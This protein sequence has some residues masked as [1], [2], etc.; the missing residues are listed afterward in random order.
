MSRT[1][2]I[3]LIFLILLIPLA[4]GCPKP[5]RCTLS[6][7][8]SRVSSVDCRG[9]GFTY[10]PYTLD[11]RITSLDMSGN[12]LRDISRDQLSSYPELTYLDLSDNEIQSVPAKAFERL[13]DLEVL[14]LDRNGIEMIKQDQFVG[15]RTLKILDLSK[16]DISRIPTSTFADMAR[17]E[18]LNISRN[19]LMDISPGAFVGLYSLLE[20]SLENNA[21]AKMDPL[22]LKPLGQLR[23]LDLGHNVINT[24]ESNSFRKQNF[25]T[26]LDLR[27]NSLQSISRHAFRGLRSLKTLNLDFNELQS[28][29]S[30]ALGSLKS[31]SSLSIRGNRFSSIQTSAFDGLSLL[32]SLTLSNCASLKAI[33]MNAFSGLFDLETLVLADNPFLSDISQFA[34]EPDTHLRQLFLNGNNLTTLIEGTFSADKLET[35]D[36]RHNPWNCNCDFKWIF[37]SLSRVYGERLIHNPGTCYTPESMTGRS[38]RDPNFGDQSCENEQNDRQIITT[39]VMVGGVLFFLS[40]LTVGAFSCRRRLCGAARKH[41]F[42]PP[43]SSPNPS[44]TYS[45]Y[46]DPKYY[47][48]SIKSGKSLPDT[49]GG[50]SNCYYYTDELWLAAAEERKSFL[51]SSGYYSNISLQRS[52]KEG[53]LYKVVSKYPVPITEL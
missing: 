13:T 46:L 48:T 20:L 49:K 31:L 3:H 16:N 4:S 12:K 41:G 23:I 32:A 18:L 35:L 26:T 21:L 5:C 19:V 22:S 29:P 2:L 42:L 17:L 10:I 24:L 11:P 47:C 34:F 7:D 53:T 1:I 39:I 44:T 40:V 27:S 6:P 45:T 43:P 38:L 51:S 15:L 37:V 25:L 36:L 30:L 33:Q 52:P 9:A 14:K 8:K 28:V 50:V